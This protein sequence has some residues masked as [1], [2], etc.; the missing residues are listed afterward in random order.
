MKSPNHI[1]TLLTILA[2]TSSSW[3]AETPP[4]TT[5]TI[6][7]TVGL[8]G[9]TM[10]GLPGAPLTDENGR[11]VAKVR[12]GWR[13]MVTPVK[14]GD[15]FDP[16]AR[17][18]DRVTADCVNQDYRARLIGLTISGNATLPSVAMQGLPGE[19]LSDENGRYVAKIP[20]GWR[21]AV[22]PKKPG[23]KFSPPRKVYSA[24]MKDSNSQDYE[25]E[26]ITFAIRGSAGL[27]GVMMQGLPEDPM[28]DASGRYS[29]QVPYGWTGRVVPTK[30]GCMFEPVS[31]D[32]AV[33]V[34]HASNQDYIPVRVSVAPSSPYGAG[35]ID[36]LVIP[37][38]PVDPQAIVEIREDMQ[39]MV[40]ILCE[41]LS[42]P[43]MIL[44]MLYDYGDIFGRSDRGTRAFYLEGYGALFVMEV[45]FPFSFPSEAGP[46]EAPEQEADP[47]WQRARQRLRSPGQRRAYGQ[48]PG[49]VMSFEQFK[50]DLIKTLKHAANIRH[51]DPNENVIL[52]IISQ[53]TAG[54]RADFSSTR[55]AFPGAAGSPFG[56]SSYST[57]GGSFG[58]EGGSTYATSR[59]YA[60]GSVAPGAQAPAR[61][62]S[63]NAKRGPLGDVTYQ[64]QPAPAST[65]ILTIQAKKAAVDAF[66]KGN[67]N[68]EQ[69]QQHVKVFTY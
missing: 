24:A 29:V 54:G 27:P 1:F 17:Q 44:G 40:H 42:E 5:F 48:A 59:S 64:S 15:S 25:P 21:G 39:V 53:D 26:M 9:V 37:S 7:G 46:E 33:V 16:P 55:G 6:A 66:S 31:R 36:V 61:D 8:P 41:M 50:E 60:G 12:L 2:V 52:T 30:Q 11:Y 57:S 22:I 32:Y 19:P 69:F 62:P 4:E 28:T 18:Y 67:I 65:T 23:Y 10:Q 68:F 13:G 63:G 43:R 58:P 14:V 49:D 56:G 3:A 34:A 38:S 20:Y 45:D 51:I 35:G 47:V